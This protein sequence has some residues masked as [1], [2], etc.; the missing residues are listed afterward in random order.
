MKEVVDNIQQAIRVFTNACTIPILVNGL[1]PITRQERVGSRGSGSLF[2]FGD[3]HYIITAAHVLEDYNVASPRIGIPTSLNSKGVVTLGQCSVL[4]LK[5]PTSRWNIDIGAIELDEEHLKLLDKRYRFLSYDNI[6]VEQKSDKAIINGFPD[7]YTQ[8]NDDVKSISVKPFCFISTF[9]NTEESS[10]I[11]ENNEFSFF[12]N[13]GGLVFTTIDGEML[14]S[15]LDLGGLSGAPV[16]QNCPCKGIWSVEKS[17]K[18]V[19][20]QCSVSQGKW[21]KGVKAGYLSTFFTK[22]D[23]QISRKLREI[24]A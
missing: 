13:W 17:L 6:E 23:E 11:M 8:Y 2:R 20:V 14:D 4:T 10:Q 18:F 24:G 3:K 1:D 9:M 5:N 15:G 16:F 21:I 22:I 19:G 7:S 12:V